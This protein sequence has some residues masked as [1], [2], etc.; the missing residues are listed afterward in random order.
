MQTQN[1]NLQKYCRGE[2]FIESFMESPFRIDNY[3][4][5]TDGARMIFIESD[6]DYPTARQEVHRRAREMIVQVL[7][8]E[9]QPLGRRR[10]AMGLAKPHNGFLRNG[11]R[12]ALSEHEKTYIREHWETTSDADMATALDRSPHSIAVWRSRNGLVGRRGEHQPHRVRNRA[13]TQADRRQVAA[14]LAQPASMVAVRLGLT[15]PQ[16]Q[17]IRR[18]LV[19][20]TPPP[21]GAFTS[22]CFWPSSDDNIDTLRSWLTTTPPRIQ[23]DIAWL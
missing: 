15:V 21:N 11:V 10:N 18:K 14:T 3:V 20:S 8:A 12:F 9:F 6:D 17:R 16:V 1:I 4:V 23:P 5:A 7:N 22:H 13:I 2:G 19:G